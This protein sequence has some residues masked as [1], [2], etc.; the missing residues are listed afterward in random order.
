[1]EALQAALTE[2]VTKLDVLAVQQAETPAEGSYPGWMDDAGY[3][4]GEERTV[5]GASARLAAAV[6]AYEE[7]REYTRSR[8]ASLTPTFENKMKVVSGKSMIEPER[9]VHTSI[10]YTT[11][12][13]YAAKF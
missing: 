8:L 5:K 11:C 3:M 7:Q 12:M 1:M 10:H 13:R 2:A 4:G 6:K 9:L